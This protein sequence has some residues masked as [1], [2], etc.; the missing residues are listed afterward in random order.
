MKDLVFLFSELKETDFKRQ[1]LYE[2]LREPLSKLLQQKSDAGK[3]P[4]CDHGWLFEEIVS[5]DFREDILFVMYRTVR[6]NKITTSLFYD[7]INEFLKGYL[8]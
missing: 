5:L 3:T 2:D 8:Q 4:F 1:E 7:E 6:G